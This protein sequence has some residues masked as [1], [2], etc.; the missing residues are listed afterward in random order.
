MVLVVV[1]VVI[2][3]IALLKAGKRE[4]MKSFVKLAWQPEDA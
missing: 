3:G 2:V 1:V 4:N